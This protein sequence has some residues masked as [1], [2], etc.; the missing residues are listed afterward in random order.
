MVRDTCRKCG[1]PYAMT[2]APRIE[3]VHADTKA[4]FEGFPYRACPQGHRSEFAYPDFGSELIDLVFKGIPTWRT[5]GIL[6][7]RALCRSCGGLLDASRQEP[8]TFPIPL[9][10]RNE[11]RFQ[12]EITAPGVRCPACGLCQVGPHD[13]VFTSEVAEAL[14]AAIKQVGL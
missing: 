8:A 11:F 7:R 5:E 9:N 3:G 1:Q 12:L 13:R 6:G 2:T 4:V 10:L 14:T